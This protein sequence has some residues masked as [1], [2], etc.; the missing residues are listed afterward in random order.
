[1][2]MNFKQAAAEVLTKANVPRQR[3]NYYFQ[4]QL[5]P[6]AKKY[7]FSETMS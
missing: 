2:T 4:P 3:K 5:D 1:M 6:K 7:L